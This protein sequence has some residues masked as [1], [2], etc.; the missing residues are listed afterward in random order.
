MEYRHPRDGNEALLIGQVMGALLR[1]HAE[2]KRLGDSV[3]NFKDI[4]PVMIGNDYSNAILVEKA[5][6]Q[7]LVTVERIEGELNDE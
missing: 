5:S 6:G 2:D 7:Y 1:A 3:Q 4:V